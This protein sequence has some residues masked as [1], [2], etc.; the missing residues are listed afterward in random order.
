MKIVFRAR[1]PR[2]DPT[3]VLAGFFAFL[4]F[5]ALFTAGLRGALERIWTDLVAHPSGPFAFRFWIQPAIAAGLGIAEGVKVAHTGGR[6]RRLAESIRAIARILVIGMAV[7]VIYQLAVL[8]MVFPLEALLVA[9]LF[10]FIPYALVRGGAAR[11]AGIGM[12]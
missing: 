5:D 7:D 11:I 9:V 12:A 1:E 10:A 3:V 4:V 2:L 8:K 6:H